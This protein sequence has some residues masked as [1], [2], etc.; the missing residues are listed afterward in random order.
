MALFRTL[1]VLAILIG[2]AIAYPV[3]RAAAD[4]WMP[5]QRAIYYSADRHI[6]LTVTPRSLD[7]QLGYYRDKVDGK[8]PAGQG[9]GARTASGLLERKDAKGRWQTIWERPLINDVAPVNAVISA[10][11]RYVATFDNWASVGWGGNVVVI[12]GPDGT[13]VRS[14]ALTD[15][16]PDYYVRALPHSVSSIWWGGDHAFARNA[17]QLDLKVMIP[18]DDG[19]GL[20]DKQEFLTMSIDPTTGRITPPTGDAWPAAL[21]KARLVAASIDAEEAKRRAA[22]I[23]PLLGPSTSAER[24][25]HQYLTEAFFRSAPDWQ[26]N[27]PQTVVLRAPS[28]PDYAASKKWTRDALTGNDALK[29][30]L[31]MIA[32]PSSEENLA[33]VVLESVGSMKPGWLK[34]VR[35]IIVATPPFQQRLTELLTPSGATLTL[36]DPAKPI[37]QR[38]ERLPKPDE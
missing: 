18:S 29:S 20:P 35:L 16:V 37:P 21:A 23:A 26:G 4:S 32:S 15:I 14:F 7:S 34:G 6:R 28:A 11:G 30:D 9:N 10:S 17:D 24:D 12:Y 19:G 27:F 2:V 25:W 5:P 3:T 33:A 8:E 22:Q 38:P 13:L 1:I 31:I 36:L